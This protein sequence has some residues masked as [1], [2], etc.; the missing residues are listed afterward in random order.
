MFQPIYVG[1]LA[2]FI[3]KTINL[4]SRIFN[5]AGPNILTF[6]E[7]IKIIL[8]YKRIKRFLLPVPFFVA[9]FL[10]YFM[11]K[12]PQPPLTKDQVKLLKKDNVSKTG[13]SNLSKYVRNPKSLEVIVPTYIT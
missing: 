8:K 5:L 2:E 9:N 12:F 3:L 4:K 6:K 10:A 1:D 13:Y 11:E 7:I